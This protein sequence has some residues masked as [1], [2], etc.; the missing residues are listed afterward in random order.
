MTETPGPDAAAGEPA[1][2]QAAAQ[3]D[4]LTGAAPD[5]DEIQADDPNHD[6]EATEYELRSGLPTSPSD[7]DPGSMLNR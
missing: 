2:E 5:A 4:A 6:P 7:Q 3:P 1:G